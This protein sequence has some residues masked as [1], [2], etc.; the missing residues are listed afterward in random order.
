MQL[1]QKRMRRGWVG[2]KER[3]KRGDGRKGW[4]RKGGGM[5]GG[6]EGKG[7]E[8]MSRGDEGG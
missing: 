8:E 5:G 7:G 6:G 1:G 2:E 3:K 4:E